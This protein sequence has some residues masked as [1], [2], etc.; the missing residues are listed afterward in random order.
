MATAAENVAGTT[1]TKEALQDR[2]DALIE[3]FK[4]ARPPEKARL[5]FELEAVIKELLAME[6]AGAEPTPEAGAR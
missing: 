3:R 5:V 2:A 6:E 4:V 1:T